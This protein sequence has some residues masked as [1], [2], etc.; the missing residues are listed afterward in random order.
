MGHLFSPSCYVEVVGGRGG[1][2]EGASTCKEL[3]IA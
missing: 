1:S 3:H 2:G